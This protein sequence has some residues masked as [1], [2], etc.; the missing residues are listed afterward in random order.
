VQRH[1]RV[2]ILQHRARIIKKRAMALG[3]EK[4]NWLS[5]AASF[6]FLPKNTS[7]KYHRAKENAQ[8][9]QEIKELVG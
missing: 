8:W 7:K 1:E 4:G 6:I 3:E 9:M 5:K 2:N